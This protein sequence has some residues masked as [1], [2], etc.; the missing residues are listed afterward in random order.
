M[1]VGS[2][3][4]AALVAAFPIDADKAAAL[5][6]SHEVHP[7]KLWKKGLLLL[8]VVDYRATNIGKYI[9]YSIG[10][11][12][13]HGPRPAPRL[14]PLLLSGWFG[15]GGWVIDMPVSTL[16]SVKG[17]KG[18]W[19]M[20]KHQASLN[21]IE[22]EEIVSSQYDDEGKLAIYIEIKR[23][24]S[25]WLPVSFGATGYS[26]YRGL[27]T[28]STIYLKGKAGM[29][30]FGKGSAR[31]VVGDAPR[32]QALKS[33]GLEPDPVVT[34]YFPQVTGVLDDHFETWFVSHAERPA[35]PPEGL[36]TVVGLPL[37][38]EWLPPPTA[39]VPRG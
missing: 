35:A 33:I 2:S 27:M 31:L 37:S 18:I 30:L 23:P 39:P 13:T 10:I 7:L 24:K 19:G 20:P 15:T 38:E 5:I 1:P 3:R 11:A 6:E 17:G 32:L 4:A 21:F 36:E 9:E 22:T 16:I 26:S 34:M 8:T 14:L 28:R 29:A 25:I 12:C